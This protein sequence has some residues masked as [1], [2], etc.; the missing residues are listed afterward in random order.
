[1]MGITCDG[2][3]VFFLQTEVVHEGLRRVFF[4]VEIEGFRTFA[5]ISVIDRLQSF[6]PYGTD[7]LQSGETLQIAACY[8]I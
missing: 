4:S 8:L 3:V 7:L 1:M 2:D 6:A 5:Q